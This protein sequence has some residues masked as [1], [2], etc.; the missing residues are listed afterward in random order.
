DE[1]IAQFRRADELERAYYKAENIP[2]EFDWHH[3]HN[4]DLLA[5]SYQYQG[6]IKQA[7]SLMREAFAIPSTQDTLEFNK[8]QWPAFL[9]LRGRNEEAIEASMMLAKSRW[10][11][12]RSIGHVMASHA[13]LAMNKTA[14]AAEQAK[15]AL[16][17]LKDSGSRAQ[18]V[19]PYLES[20]Q[21]EF[22]LRTGQPDKG[23]TIL[24][25]VERKLR[26][27]QSPDAWTQT[28]FRLEAIAR[29]AREAGDAE[30]SE[31]TA[32]QMLE[33]DPSYGGTHYAIA[34]AALK[35]NDDKTA[36][37]EFSLAEKYWR[38]ADPDF[39]ELQ[40]IRSNLSRKQ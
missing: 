8:K 3:E 2:P 13:L 34:M 15:A 12:V 22:F 24:K 20:L 35:R 33:H 19:A 4:L 23:R 36:Q 26:Q 18:F 27:D 16:A 39:P 5:T 7:E 25:E 38:Q 10:D 29:V 28:L 17:E 6:R 11:I 31:Y 40:E 14:Q 21:G 37:R 30:L 9:I 1:A 32:A